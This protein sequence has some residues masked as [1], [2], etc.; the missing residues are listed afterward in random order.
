MGDL[1]LQIFGSWLLDQCGNFLPG[2]YSVE[3][4]DFINDRI[5][6]ASTLCPVQ[7]S[8]SDFQ[9]R[10]RTVARSIDHLFAVKIEFDFFTVPDKSTGIPDIILE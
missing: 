6:A 5:A 9:P 4:G 10:F 7:S 3:N 2:Q 1:K 8:E